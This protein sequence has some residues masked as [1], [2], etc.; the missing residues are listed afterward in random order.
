MN[1]TETPTTNKEYAEAVTGF[2]EKIYTKTGTDKI[3]PP[4]P[5]IPRTN[6]IK[7][8][9]IKP[10]NSIISICLVQINRCFN[11]DFVSDKSASYHIS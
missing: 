9:L 11:H 1:K 7:K 4:P 5:S 8:A 10:K 2:N 3:E 6:P